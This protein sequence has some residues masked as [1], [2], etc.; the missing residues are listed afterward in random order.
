MSKTPYD[1]GRPPGTHIFP[2]PELLYERYKNDHM[3]VAMGT[4]QFHGPYTQMWTL[5]PGSKREMLFLAFMAEF[6]PGEARPTVTEEPE[7]AAV[8]P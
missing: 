6:M 3:T 4:L 7:D 1:P 2:E 8:Q 5:E